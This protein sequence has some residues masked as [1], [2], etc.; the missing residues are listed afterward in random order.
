MQIKRTKS[1]VNANTEVEKKSPDYIEATT[2]IQKA[3][4]CLAS[5]SDDKSK[6]AIGDL[7]VVLFDLK[8]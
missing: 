4:E 1:T 3:I 5:I 8:G 6:T 7:S 2:H